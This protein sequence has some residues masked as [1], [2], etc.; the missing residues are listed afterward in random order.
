VQTSQPP[1][2]LPITGQHESSSSAAS[3]ASESAPIRP[4]DT[5]RIDDD[6]NDLEPEDDA[7][8][9]DDGHA[10]ATDDDDNVKQTARARRSAYVGRGNIQAVREAR[11]R[12]G[13]SESFPRSDPLLMESWFPR[14]L[15]LP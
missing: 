7:A 8:D 6:D 1:P 14:L 13:L 5:D 2:A 4:V 9:D 10:D 15:E 12:A 3:T 11:K